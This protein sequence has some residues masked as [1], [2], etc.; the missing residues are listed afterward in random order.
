MTSKPLPPHGSLSRHKWHGCKCRTCY[1]GYNEWQR[2]HHAAKR[3]NTYN[4]LVDAE[5]VRQHILQLQAAG[6]STTKL[7]K[8]LG[9]HPANITSFVRPP[10]V[11]RPRKRRTNPETA[12]RILAV[13]TADII[14]GTIDATG[15]RRRIQAL[16]AIGWPLVRLG[17]IIGIH[18]GWVDD[19]LKKE[20]TSG[21]TAHSVRLAFER[22]G[23]SSP[24]RHGVSKASAKRAR[25][26][27]ASLRWAP[28]KY[29][30]RFP[31]AIDDPH[32]TPEYGL[33]KADLL[34]EEA[35]FL[36]T[37]AG[38]T[39]TEA[40]I[41]LGKDRTYVDRVLGPRGPQSA[42]GTAA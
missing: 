11:G 17:P 9:Y 20:V 3:G 6:I 21:Q 36:V 31:D 14:P 40:A 22:L 1:D 32:F 16:A 24:E 10:G 4:K 12:A 19:L 26:R 23:N 7:A 39:R 37:V 15:T 30:A 29:W 28:P 2:Q 41:R 13:T 18:P 27:A 33:S 38:L 34:A 35:T 5:P 25:R 8:H 42:L